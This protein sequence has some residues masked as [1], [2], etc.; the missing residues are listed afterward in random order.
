MLR[1]TDYTKEYLT[2]E[3]RRLAATFT[4]RSRVSRVKWSVEVSERG[5]RLVVSWTDRA[6]GWLHEPVSQQL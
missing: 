4:P 1:K 2:A 5:C 3:A 6:T